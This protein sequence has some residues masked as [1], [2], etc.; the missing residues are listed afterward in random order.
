MVG[1]RRKGDRMRKTQKQRT[2]DYLT[3]YHKLNPI[4]AWQSLGIYRLSDVILKLR[5]EGYEIETDEVIVKNKFGENCKVAEYRY[6][7]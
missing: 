1:S 4:K 5:R 3:R 6:Y 2:I 7:G